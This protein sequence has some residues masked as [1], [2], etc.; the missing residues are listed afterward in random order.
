QIRGNIPAGL[1]DVDLLGLDEVGMQ[2]DTKNEFIFLNQI[3]DR[4]TASM[5]A[6]DTDQ[7]EFRQTEKTGR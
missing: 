6:V 2:R 4:Q 1:C 5:K 7:P 3:V